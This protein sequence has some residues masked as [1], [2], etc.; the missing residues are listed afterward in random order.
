M[1]VRENNPEFK[2]FLTTDVK[3]V[4]ARKNVGKVALWANKSQNAK[5]PI[6]TGTVQTE[7]GSYRIVLWKFEPKDEGI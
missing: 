4:K 5:A 3:D 2:G 7:K 1:K 6:Y